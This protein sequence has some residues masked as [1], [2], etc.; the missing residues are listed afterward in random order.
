GILKGLPAPD[1]FIDVN[2]VSFLKAHSFSFNSL[3]VGANTTLTDAI[4]LFRAVAVEKPAKFS[5]TAQLAKHI[6]RVANT[7]VRN[8]GTLAGN[9]SIKHASREF[10]SDIFLILEAVGAKL[11]IRGQ[12]ESVQLLSLPEY[13]ETNMYKK[14]ILQIVL[15]PMD[16]STNVVKTYRVTP[17]AQNAIAYVNAGFRFNVNRKDGF[18]LLDQPTIVFGGINPLFIHAETTEKYLVG[19]RLLDVSTLQTALSI[20]GKE[21]QP[22]YR[23][24]DSRPEYRRGLAQSLFYRV[25]L[26]LNPNSVK[27]QFRSGGEDITRPLSS[28]KQEFDTDSSRPPL[29][30]AFPKLESLIQC[31]GEAEY[32]FDKP[33]VACDLH[34]AFVIT[35]HGPAVLAGLDPSR[36]L[37][38]PGVVAFFSAKDIPGANIFTPKHAVI[39]ENEQLFA[40]K[41]IQFAGQSVGL[42]VAV[43][44][45]LA[46][47]AADLVQIQYKSKVKPVLDLRE[48]VKNNMTER[49]FLKAEQDAA[50]V[51]PDVK[52]IVRGDFKMNEQYHFALEMLTCLSVPTEDGQ[53]L[54]VFC[55]TQWQAAVH[56]AISLLLNIPQNR[57]NMRLRRLGGAYGGKLTRGNFVGGACSLAAYLLQRPVRMVVKLETMFETIGKRDPCLF[58]YE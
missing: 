35:K 53:E 10:R 47:A 23:L 7:P 48:I 19:R 1:V 22:D 57:I 26:S 45:E 28:G 33:I 58:Y 43:T 31:S 39:P 9:L 16:S 27:S 49:I 8:V 13:L 44:Q 6:E 41:N 11:S 30:Q 32:I 37:K 12:S 42:V 2:R 17:R 15:P 46:D 5:Y 56:E 21:V 14:V 52:K 20:L 50:A 36:A 29:Y 4:T 54:D 3:Q 40:D 25:V 24:P 38:V 34:A 51:K 18:R 55:T